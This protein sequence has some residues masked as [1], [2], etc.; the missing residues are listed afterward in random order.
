MVFYRYAIISLPAHMAVLLTFGGVL[1]NKAVALAREKYPYV[2]LRVGRFGKGAG[3]DPYILE[4]AGR[5]NDRLTIKILRFQHWSIYCFLAA[6][7][8]NI[9]MWCFSAVLRQAG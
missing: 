4:E 5:S 8:G 3:W 6:L 1:S 2:L 9:L 7:L